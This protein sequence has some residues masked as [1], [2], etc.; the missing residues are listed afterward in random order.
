ML[1]GCILPSESWGCSCSRQMLNQVT[2]AQHRILVDFKP[3][4]CLSSRNSMLLWAGQGASISEAV[5][6]PVS[7]LIMLCPYVTLY[8]VVVF[9]FFLSFPPLQLGSYWSLP[10]VHNKSI[11]EL[12]WYL[13]I[14]SDPQ[15]CQCYHAAKNSHLLNS[16]IYLLFWGGVLSGLV[17]LLFGFLGV[18]FLGGSF[19]FYFFFL[20]FFP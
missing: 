7:G 4:R 1:S 6:P 18:F 2:F 9:H 10:A 13:R 20:G 5:F 3:A 17:F 11:L 8:F 16:F 14:G 19:F 12:R 15:L